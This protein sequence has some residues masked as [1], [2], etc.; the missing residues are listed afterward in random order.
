MGGVS[1]TIGPGSGPQRV[2]ANAGHELVHALLCERGVRPAWERR[3][4]WLPLRADGASPALTQPY[5]LGKLTS[6]QLTRREG[7]CSCTPSSGA[8]AGGRPRT[9]RQPPSAHGRL[10]TRRCP[11]TSAGLGAT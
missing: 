6:T 5:V 3:G 2:L 1:R 10:A 4:V 11:T 9:W 8:E 7:T